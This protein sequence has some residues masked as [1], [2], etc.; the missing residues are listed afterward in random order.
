MRCRAKGLRDAAPHPADGHV[1]AANLRP[2]LAPIAVEQ[3]TI[4]IAFRYPYGWQSYPSQSSVGRRSPGGEER[5]STREKGLYD[6]GGRRH[7]ELS[8]RRATVICCALAAVASATFASVASADVVP[9]NTTFPTFEARSL[10]GQGNNVAHP[11]AG[12]ARADYIRIAKASYANGVSTQNGGPNARV[13]SNRIFNDVGQNL[14]SERNIEPVGPAIWGQFIDHTLGLAKG[15]T[16]NDNICDQQQRP[17][18]GRS[19][20]DRGFIA[21]GRVTP[22]RCQARVTSIFNPRQHTNTTNS[23]ISGWQVYGG[24]ERPARVA[25]RRPGRR[26]PEQQQ[27]QR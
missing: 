27:R 5:G 6:D 18:R 10:S 26:Q 1:D 4:D 19:R 16:E 12:A 15:G 2:R 11:N 24:S 25:A 21:I 3:G 14:F 17:A 8:A 20:N 7:R 13:V 23:F 9:G 22:R